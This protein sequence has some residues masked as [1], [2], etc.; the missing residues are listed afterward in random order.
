MTE[1]TNLHK[2]FSLSFF[3]GS[4]KVP[5][6]FKRILFVCCLCFMNLVFC[7]GSDI[8]FLLW[9]QLDAYPDSEL[10]QKSPGEKQFE[11][12]I[13]SLKETAPFL[14]QGMVYGWKFTYTPSD[15]T[16]GVK[17]YFE[18]EPVLDREVLVPQIRYENPRISEEENRMECWISVD[19]TFHQQNIYK[20]WEAVKNPVIHGVGEGEVEKGFEGI[21]DAVKKAVTNAVRDYYRNEVK[22]KPKEITGTVLIRRNPI[23]GIIDGKYRINLDFFL[24]KGKIIT[25]TIF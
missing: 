9:A 4:I 23:L 24:E 21:Q 1:K 15:K 14:I 19:R 8:R 7:F 16:R 5:A 11:F 3:S 22:N 2:I 25:Y 6:V 10:A 18:L 17:E 12:P 20:Q 13:N